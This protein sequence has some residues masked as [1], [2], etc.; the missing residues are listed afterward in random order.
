MQP[1]LLVSIHDV[2][3][4]TLETS[5]RVV[6]MVVARGVPLGALTV[7]VIP[8]HEDGPTLE[9]DAPTCRW[10]HDLAD[11]GASLC[12]H[13]LTHRMA[14]V[15]RGPW[16]W[17]WAHGFARGQGELYLGDGADCQA[18]LDVARA[19]LQRCGLADR[20]HGFVPP[21]WLLSP[22]AAE[23]VSRAGFAYLEELGGI[24]VGAALH[25]RRLIGFGSLNAVESRVTAAH[26]WL[27][28]HRPPA[29]TR[30]AIHPA[31]WH[32]ASTRRAIDR[33]LRRLLPVSRPMN[34]VDYLDAKG[35]VP[36]PRAAQP[37][38]RLA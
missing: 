15:A 28:S 24:R 32:R 30:L 38:V 18:R 10:L 25:A 21:A 29:D 35:P 11:A 22:A 9:T 13:G 19:I 36:S 17:L 5:R 31:D 16:Q 23:A 34:Y 37:D 4:S 27:Q 6:R 33:T 12:L 8:Q 20:V 1:A 3:P 14:G 7:L 26:A 2:S